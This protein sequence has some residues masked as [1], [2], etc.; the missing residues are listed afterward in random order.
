MAE[1]LR[2]LRLTGGGYYTQ[3]NGPPRRNGPDVEKLRTLKRSFSI[4]FWE[5]NLCLLIL[6]RAF[7]LYAWLNLSYFYSL[8]LTW[9]WIK[10]PLTRC[11]RHL[12]L[13]WRTFS[14]NQC[15]WSFHRK[16]VWLLVSVL[17]LPE[18]I[19]P[20]QSFKTLIKPQ[21]YIAGSYKFCILD[22]S[23]LSMS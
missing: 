14:M 21:N 23:Y 9:H 13:Q 10:A 2:I 7:L 19:C 8:Y 18:Q 6:C 5:P 15:Y 3:K 11:L 12:L 1:N 20:L 4:I 22:C 17:A 16:L